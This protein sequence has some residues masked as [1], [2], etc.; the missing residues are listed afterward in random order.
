MATTAINC[1]FGNKLY[2]VFNPAVPV[3]NGLVISI[4]AQYGFAKLPAPH[5]HHTVWLKGVPISMEKNSAEGI[6]GII[7]IVNFFRTT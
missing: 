4:C 5:I 2:T 6:G 7:K 3:I 1:N